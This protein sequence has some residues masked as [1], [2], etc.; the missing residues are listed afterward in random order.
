M[1]RASEVPPV[2]VS[3]GLNP[4]LKLIAEEI[5]SVKNPGEVKK[6]SPDILVSIVLGIE[7]F[8]LFFL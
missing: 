3:F 8:F 4:V 7:I 2:V 1:K 6:D 5:V